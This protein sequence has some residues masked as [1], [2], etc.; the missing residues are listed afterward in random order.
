M[1][2]SVITVLNCITQSSPPNVNN[3][4]QGED[5]FTSCIVQK[6]VCVMVSIL[7]PTFTENCT[8]PRIDAK[9]ANLFGNMGIMDIKILKTYKKPPTGEQL[10]RFC[11]I[12][13]TDG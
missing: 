13:A 8:P 4:Y 11:R 1:E 7:T 2:A 9:M 6:D 12:F 3:K 10:G 5:C